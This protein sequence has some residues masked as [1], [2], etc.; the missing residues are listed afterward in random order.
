MADEVKGE[1][2]TPVVPTEIA[3]PKPTPEPVNPREALEAEILAKNAE[4]DEVESTETEATI[5]PAKDK[6]EVEPKLE[7]SVNP[8]ERIKADMLKRVNKLTARAKSAEEEL[9]ELRAENER[10]RKVGTEPKVE[11]KPVDKNAEPTMEQCE[12][13]LE[14]AFSE[15]DHKFAAQITKYMAE[16]TAKSQR[17]EA[18][19]AFAERNN[20][21]TAAQ[22]KELSDW[23]NLC[24]D[25]APTDSEGK[26]DAKHP[27]NL[28]NQTGLLYKTALGLYQDKD[29][30]EKYAG[31]DK[32]TGFRL[33]VNDAHR[34]I[35]EQGL[36]KPVANAKPVVEKP[37]RSSKAV[38]AEPD[39]SEGE[40]DT[41]QA[42]STNSNDMSDA[43]KARAEI[44]FRTKN[45]YMRRVPTR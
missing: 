24:N 8:A 9:A 4:I 25:F 42:V 40:E 27:L 16:L 43:E 29:L 41:S 37:E 44:N 2:E 10:L 12:A 28:S 34:G 15:G 32:M 13:A 23:V 11:A 19:K 39:A 18:E 35:L 36:Y 7:E 5:E 14:K 3:E 22:K 38:L 30:R 21:Q 6:A 33:A 45:R 1:L 17:A 20:Q 26:L 31:Y